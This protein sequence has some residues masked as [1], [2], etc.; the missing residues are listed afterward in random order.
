MLDG[1][2]SGANIE[3]NELNLSANSLASDFADFQIY[4]DYASVEYGKMDES[5]WSL[6]IDYISRFDELAL[7]DGMFRPFLGAGIGYMS[8][9]TTT[10]LKRRWLDLVHFRWDRSYVYR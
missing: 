1:G 4:L 2:K 5:L 3:G 7:A 6:G 10:L 8:D 9:K